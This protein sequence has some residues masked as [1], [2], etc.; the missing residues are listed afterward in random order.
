MN[1]FTTTLGGVEVEIDFGAAALDYGWPSGGLLGLDVE[2]TY[3]D[4]R[5]Q[6]A[7]DFRV[8]TV[9][10]GTERS[11]LVFDVSD[12]AQRERVEAILRDPA[13]SFCSHTNMD[14]ISVWREFGID[15]TDR[16]LD[17]HELASIADPTMAAARDLK[18]LAAAHG[19]GEL[20]AGEA[21]LHALFRELYVVDGGKRNAARAKVDEF[22]W[23]TV[24]LDSELFVTYA[25]LDAIACRRLADLLVPAT[26]APAELL[27]VDVWLATRANRLTLTGKRVDVP[28]LEALYAES[29]EAFSEAKAAAE[30]IAGVN[31]SGPKIIDWLGQEGVNWNSWEGQLTDS[32]RPSLAKANLALVG[33]HDLSGDARAV[34]GHMTTMQEHADVLRKTTDIRDRL[35]GDRIHPQLN[36]VGAATTGRMSASAPNM[37]NFSKRDPRLRGL[38]LPD[39]GCVLATIDFAQIELRVVAALARE[40]S[41]IETIKAGGD[42]HQLTVDRL[43]ERGVTITRDAAKMANFLIVYGGGAKAL[44]EQIRQ[45]P[46]SSPI[47]MDAAREV[48]AGMREVY[49]AISA[50]TKWKG[51]EREAIRTISNRRLPVTRNKRGDLRTY[52]N[53]NYVVQSAARELLVTAWRRLEE[54]RPGIVWWPIHDELVLQVPVNEVEDV[55][56][57]AEKAM[58]GDF[59]GVPVTADAV[60]LLDENGVSRWMDSK[61]A[62]KIAKERHA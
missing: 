12:P 1:T 18:S 21:T 59:R 49:P 58:R 23:R 16:N 8:R 47:P 41:M 48:V 36:P 6:F 5:G 35:V 17:T 60:V 10:F 52:A 25:G 39:D 55:L 33:D 7:P 57:D 14:V 29:F 15:I 37:Q 19:M 50:L 26:Q 53:V 61:R 31:P 3:M 27:E 40:E 13:Y 44:Y 42:L 24:P 11:G 2:S 46:Y 20:A 51:Y 38:F 30:E 22:G 54:W 32:G 56:T 28:R 9:Q 34:F 45:P 62:E 43:A 4:S